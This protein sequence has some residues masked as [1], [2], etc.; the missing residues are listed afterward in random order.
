MTSAIAARALCPRL[1]VRTVAA[2]S[3]RSALTVRAM[4]S[5]TKLDKTTPEDVR[6]GG[7][8]SWPV[9]G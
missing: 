9:C 5:E 8:G 4:S 3:R 7:L 2:R 6:P 1:V